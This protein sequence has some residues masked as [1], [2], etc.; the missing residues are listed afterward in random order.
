MSSS[1]PE[2]TVR[3]ARLEDAEAVSEL[4]AAFDERYSGDADL[5]ADDVREE[6]RRVDLEQDSW[7]WQRGG[8]IVAHAALVARG[9]RLDADGYVHPDHTGLGLGSLIL[10]TTEAR[11]RER[12]MPCLRNAIMASDC[13][14]AHLLE[15]HGYRDARHFYRMAIDMTEPPPEPRWPEGLE[16]RA[17]DLEDARAFFAASQEAFEDEWGH[18]PDQFESFER[19]RLESPRFDPSLW[20]VVWDRDL[21]AATL[22]ADP[23]YSDA[24]WIASVGVRRF[25]RR[26]GLGLALL[27]RAFGQFWERGERRVQ[28]GVDAQNSTGAT[29][30]YERAGMHVAWEAVVYQK[31]LA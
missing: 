28:L 25:W 20:T 27:H 10:E 31:E 19:R 8:T 23:K 1:L 9:E 22:I 21:I 11:A 18:V 2:L 3:P 5:T 17:F 4:I 6:W 16:P 13:S 29:R 12:G 15:E 14:A 30:L 24:G 7:I 26:R